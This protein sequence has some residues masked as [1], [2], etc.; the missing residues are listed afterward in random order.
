MLDVIIHKFAEW[1]G[2]EVFILREDLLPLACGGNKVRIAQKLIEDA[3]GKGEDKI[4]GYGNSR[5]NFCRALAMLCAKEG[6]L[7]E[8]V[9]P[10]DADGSRKMTTN[11]KIAEICGAKIIR[12][13]KSDDIAMVVEDVLKDGGYYIFGNKYGKGNEKILM[14][15]YEEVARRIFEWEISHD[16][17]FDRIV[18]AVGTGSTYA[19]LARGVYG[20]SGGKR[21]TGYTIAR[22]NKIC[23]ERIKEFAD[24]S[25]DIRDNARLNGYGEV[26]DELILFLRS[27]LRH[28]AIVF[29]SVYS[30]KA[31]F[32]LYKDCLTRFYSGERVLFVHTGSLPLGLDTL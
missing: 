15:A 14:S 22:P 32:G 28:H 8:I 5:S 23:C 9:S 17:I 16:I 29:D 21:V 27:I 24:V 30:G 3:K 1:N 20:I 25:V 12:C 6:I 26:T 7:C 13:N 10:S 4:V 18:L 2:N 31:L 11:S 19:G